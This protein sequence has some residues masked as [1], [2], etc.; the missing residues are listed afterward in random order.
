MKQAGQEAGRDRDGAGRDIDPPPV[1][2]AQ[3]V[4]RLGDRAILTSERSTVFDRPIEGLGA[5]VDPADEIRDPIWNHANGTR[6][7][8]DLVHCRLV[9]V[10]EITLR[11]PGHLRR[12]LVS[13]IGNMAVEASSAERKAPPSA[14]EI[15]LADWTWDEL[16]KLPRERFR[17]LQS[18]AFGI[19]YAKISEAMLRQGVKRASLSAVRQWDIEERRALAGVWQASKREVDGVTFDRWRTVFEKARK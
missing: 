8:P 12:Q 1:T 18:R 17:L 4:R 10:G 13:V 2:Y 6:W 11:M 9:V 15:T 3:P 5:D 14:A 7:T 19:S 16:F